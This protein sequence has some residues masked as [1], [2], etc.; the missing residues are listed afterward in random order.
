MAY[1]W[2]AVLKR[3][4]AEIQA[5]LSVKKGMDDPQTK[6]WRATMVRRMGFIHARL[7]EIKSLKHIATDKT[8]EEQLRRRAANAAKRV[9][10][11]RHYDEYREL[12]TEQLAQRG[13]E[14]QNL[15][16]EDQGA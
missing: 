9:L 14:F 4:I 12:L 16:E 2:G 10:V 15:Q 1:R 3:R 6:D 11:A 5:D 13:L 8:S 7:L